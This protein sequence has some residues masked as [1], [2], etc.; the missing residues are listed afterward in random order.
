MAAQVELN[1]KSRKLSVLSVG[2]LLKLQRVTS[3]GAGGMTGTT[4]SHL[5]WN[6]IKWAQHFFQKCIEIFLLPRSFLTQEKHSFLLFSAL[7]FWPCSEEYGWY[8]F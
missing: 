7:N 1:R 2:I 3:S 6:G 8:M 5:T 4:C